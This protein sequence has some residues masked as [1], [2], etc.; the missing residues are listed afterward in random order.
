MEE[1]AKNSEFKVI[2]I[3]TALLLIFGVAMLV[4]SLTVFGKPLFWD[5]VGGTIMSK[6]SNSVVL[7]YVH[8][9][10]TY[11]G[12]E[13]KNLKLS[14]GVGD[15]IAIRVN[16]ANPTEITVITNIGLLIVMFALSGIMIAGGIAV[17]VYYFIKNRKAAK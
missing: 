17:P 6:T 9:G 5:E 13:I 4:L 14:A 12:T 11:L 2:T 3:F 8:N 16:P 15:T 7:Q 10:A 1:K